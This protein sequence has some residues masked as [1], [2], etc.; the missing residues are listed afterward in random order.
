MFFYIV[1]TQT[2]TTSGLWGTD[3]TH[4]Y[5]QVDVYI[6]QCDYM[7]MFY[8]MT[9]EPFVMRSEYLYSQFYFIDSL[10]LS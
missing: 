7:S 1:L 6:Y 2:S 4:K 3:N 9:G 5:H 8:C 10:E